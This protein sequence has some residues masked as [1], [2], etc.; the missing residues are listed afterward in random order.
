MSSSVIP[1]ITFLGVVGL[2]AKA[3]GLDAELE[4]YDDQRLG[5]VTAEIYA[6]EPGFVLGWERCGW[7]M[8]RASWLGRRLLAFR[9]CQLTV[10]S[11][12]G[13]VAEAITRRGLVPAIPLAQAILAPGDSPGSAAGQA[14]RF[15][16]NSSYERQ[17]PR[18]APGDRALR[19]GDRY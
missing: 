10:L 12:A 2:E 5:A 1:D 15:E 17:Q 3:R 9:V 7:T 19:R 13:Q 11:P 14:F 18:R 16:G 4:T 8:R 6:Q